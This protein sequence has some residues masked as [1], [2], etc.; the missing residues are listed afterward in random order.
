MAVGG[1][2][3][4]VGPRG[5]YLHGLK[6]SS[7]GTKKEKLKTAVDKIDA[8]PLLLTK[9]KTT[10]WPLAGAGAHFQPIKKAPVGP[11]PENNCPAGVAA[12]RMFNGPQNFPRLGTRARVAH[13]GVLDANVSAGTPPHPWLASAAAR[14]I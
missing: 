5:P 6:R 7:G 9:K 8:P 4:V 10:P 1:F 13:G 12:V 3:A 11:A 2:F 14:S